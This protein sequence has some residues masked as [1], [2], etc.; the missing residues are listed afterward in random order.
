MTNQPHVYVDETQALD[1]N[2]ALTIMLP[3]GKATKKSNASHSCHINLYLTEEQIRKFSAD[4]V[5]SLDLHL[6]IAR[7]MKR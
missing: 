6:S 7:R 2:L 3:E 5:E 1:K 4:I